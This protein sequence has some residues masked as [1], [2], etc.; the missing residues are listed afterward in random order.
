MSEDD[1]E[2]A[3]KGRKS[4]ADALTKLTGVSR[5]QTGI[6]LDAVDADQFK[7]ETPRSRRSGTIH[8]KH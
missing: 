1:D 6:D 8:L 5:S 4:V 7:P 2:L 3:I